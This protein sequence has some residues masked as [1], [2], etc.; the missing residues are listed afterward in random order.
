M[1][2]ET[3][4]YSVGVT[5]WNVVNA[6]EEEDVEVTLYRYDENDDIHVHKQWYH[7]SY[8]RAVKLLNKMAFVGIGSGGGTAQQEVLLL[9]IL[10]TRPN[11]QRRWKRVMP[12]LGGLRICRN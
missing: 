5:L 2:N 8:A 11:D 3:N 6:R 9:Y 10:N 4:T 1:Q 7:L 12:Q